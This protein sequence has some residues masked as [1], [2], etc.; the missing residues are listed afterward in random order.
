MNP[1]KL[2]VDGDTVLSFDKNDKWMVDSGTSTSRLLPDEAK[3]LVSKL[4]GGDATL[5]GVLY[6]I[7]NCSKYLSQSWTIDLTLP[8]QDHG[9]AFDLQFIPADALIKIGQ[10]TCVFGFGIADQR[11][12]GN[13]I[14]QRY[15]TTYDFGDKSIGFTLK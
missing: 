2:S 14:L 5:R 1:K 4:F 7:S 11:F 8:G 12:L 9:A 6:H 15:I 13:S 3:K 10:N